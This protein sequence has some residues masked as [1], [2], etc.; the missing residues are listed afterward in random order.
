MD[1]LW[2]FTNPLYIFSVSIILILGVGLLVF[3]LGTILTQKKQITNRVD[4]F[5]NTEENSHQPIP[6]NLI[7]SR[8]ISGSLLHRTI[9]SWIKNFIRFLGRFTPER[10]ALELEHKLTIAGNPG[11]LHAGEFYA[12]RLLILCAGVIA[13]LL[14]N[15]DFRTINPTHLLF[16]G[17][18]IFISFAIPDVWLN[19]RV[20]FRQDEIRCTLPDALD[21]LSVCVSAGLGFDQSLQKISHYWNTDLGFEFTRVNKEME[22]GVSRAEALKNLSTRL[23][24][25]DLSRFVAIIV[26]AEKVGM[27]YADVLHS[28][29]QQLRVLRQYR[30]REI[31]NKLPGKMILPLALFIFPA[32]IAVIL[33][34]SI[35]MFLNLF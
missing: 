14:I 27:S 17:L 32:M 3:G 10:M 30:A 15:R 25:D 5:I 6:A 26:Q 19:G 28:Q 7:I 1:L 13:A 11:N 21:M 31:A 34:P 18:I 12:I 33:G 8:E 22:M 9:L 35:P 29:A 20:Q 2:L 23:E 24:V 4:H 16:G